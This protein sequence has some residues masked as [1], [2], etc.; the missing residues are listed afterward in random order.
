MSRAER[1]FAVQDSGE[2]PLDPDLVLGRACRPHG[3]AA[4]PILLPSSNTAN[5]NGVWVP[6]PRRRGQ[7]LSKPNAFAGEES[8]LRRPQVR[9]TRRFHS[10]SHWARGCCGRRHIDVV[11]LERPPRGVP[12]TVLVHHCCRHFPAKMSRNSGEKRGRTVKENQQKRLKTRGESKKKRANREG[13]CVKSHRKSSRAPRYPRPP[14][15]SA[16]DTPPTN[17]CRGTPSDQS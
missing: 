1:V 14:A 10:R 8:T 4:A 11:E 6:R 17:D 9:G 2:D 16:T 7:P 5:T 3:L 12:S 13:K 15:P